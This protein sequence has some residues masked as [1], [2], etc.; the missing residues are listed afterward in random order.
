MCY[1]NIM[2]D[3]PSALSFQEDL[4][5]QRRTTPGK[6]WFKWRLRAESAQA[7]TTRVWHRDMV[8]PWIKANEHV[9]SRT[10]G[11]TEDRVR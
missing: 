9:T 2:I 1:T 11:L 10:S 5:L 7:V 4:H 8:G 6:M 3:Y